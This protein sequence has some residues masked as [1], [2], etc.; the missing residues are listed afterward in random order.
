[1]FIKKKKKVKIVI[2]GSAPLR[3]SAVTFAG[4]SQDHGGCELAL[5]Q[6]QTHRCNESFGGDTTGQATRTQVPP[7]KAPSSPPRTNSPSFP[8]TVRGQVVGPALLTS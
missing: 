8:T 6:L 1:M 5:S 7:L 2:Q 4:R 3:F